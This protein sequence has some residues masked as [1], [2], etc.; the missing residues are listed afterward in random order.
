MVSYNILADYLARE[1]RNL[2]FHV[3]DHIM[4]WEW[5]KKRLL[6]EFG[7]WSPDIMCLQE[8]DRFQDLEE[9]LAL[10][11]YAGIWKMR[12]GNAVD[13]CAIFWRTNRFQ[14]RHEEH[15]EFSKLG[16]RDNVAQICLLESRIQLPA[17]NPSISLPE[18]S[19]QSSGVNQVLICNIHVL[20][21][22]K[23]GEIKLGQVRVLLERA[24]AVSKI[25]NNAPVII[26]GDFNCT[27]KSPMYNFI[28]EQKLFLSGVA[29]NQVSGQYSSNMYASQSYVGSGLYRGPQSVYRPPGAQSFED[30]SCCKETDDHF[31]PLNDTEDV[32]EDSC[33][34][35][36]ISTKYSLVEPSAK[37]S[38]N[39]I[40]EQSE[41]FVSTGYIQTDEVSP[42]PDGLQQNHGRNISPFDHS[43]SSM[44]V[45]SHLNT[46]VHNESIHSI[47]LDVSFK[48]LGLSQNFQDSSAENMNR[49]KPDEASDAPAMDKELHCYDHISKE[50]MSSSQPSYIGSILES[51]SDMLL[52]KA[53]S[54]E[55]Y[56]ENKNLDDCGANVTSF[57]TDS[58]ASSADVE[59]STLKSMEIMANF[60]QEE[61]TGTGVSCQNTCT[62]LP[63]SSASDNSLHGVGRT[64]MEDAC[65]DGDH[66]H[67]YSGTDNAQENRTRLE[68][69]RAG[70][71]YTINDLCDSENSD[72][73]F[74]KELLG[75]EDASAYSEETASPSYHIQTDSPR[76]RP[77]YDPYVWTPMEIE[78]AS[79]DAGQT[80]IEH[81][82]NLRSAYADVEDYAGTK[83]S[84]REPLV[85]SYHR[86]FMGTVDYIWCSESLQTVKVLDTIPKHVLQRTPGF[87][88]PKWGSDHL[89]L[90]CQFAFASRS[91][92]VG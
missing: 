5:R 66:G 62:I 2:Y 92:T 79:G 38:G 47:D 18:S 37:E 74:L 80:F 68:D 72:P 61:M 51:Q 35:T 44:P 69:D 25:W 41:S 33:S 22:P 52:E 57:K 28:S 15:I 78:I 84:S 13:G 6:W 73:N 14:L 31:K 9:E 55:G 53:S 4:D 71:G 64:R 46:E 56:F 7:L 85:T 91:K 36:T 83:D 43:L 75:T 65:T 23:R 12:T 67:T 19:V 42:Y 8:V 58:G 88:T 20:Y 54:T 1:H 3:P 40:N 11:G 34:D 89:A 21:N 77:S 24:Y 45:E 49:S 32:D 60:S 81:S 17:E 87:P 48:D 27:P 82:I 10:Q 86:K 63:D 50:D 26:C 29:R 59:M 90:A 39:N 70:M 16:L 30:G 76:E